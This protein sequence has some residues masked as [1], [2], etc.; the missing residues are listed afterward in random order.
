MSDLSLKL[1]PFFFCSSRLDRS[2][3][4]FEAANRAAKVAEDRA[5]TGDDPFRLRACATWYRTEAARIYWQSTIVFLQ[6][7]GRRIEAWDRIQNEKEKGKY[8]TI[9]SDPICSD[10]SFT[11]L[12]Q[13]LLFLEAASKVKTI[14]DP[15]VLTWVIAHSIYP[16]KLGY[17]PAGVVMTF[18]CNETAPVYRGT[19]TYQLGQGTDPSYGKKVDKIFTKTSNG[20]WSI[21][22]AIAIA[23][24]PHRTEIYV[25]NKTESRCT[26]ISIIA[27]DNPYFMATVDDLEPFL[28]EKAVKTVV[29]Y[30]YVDFSTANTEK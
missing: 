14:E 25:K 1:E 6:Q 10:E 17:L 15:Q 12:T 28:K 5:N 7:E 22:D 4:L 23:V 18:I 20:E 13:V 30:F 26:S 3:A 24:N 8:P 2:Q 11:V 19:R 21:M 29:D 9:C 16:A 27:T